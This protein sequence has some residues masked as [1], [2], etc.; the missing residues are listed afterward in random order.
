MANL[1]PRLAQKTQTP[2]TPASTA[3][4]QSVNSD[5]TVSLITAGGTVITANYFSSFAPNVGQIVHYVI[6]NQGY[7]V[8]TGAIANAESKMAGILVSKSVDTNLYNDTITLISFD[9]I[10]YDG[11]E[12]FNS[13]TNKFTAPLPGLYWATTNQVFSTNAT[14]FRTIYI[15][16]ETAATTELTISSWS[17]TTGSLTVVINTSTDHGL[18]AGN[19]VLIDGLTTAR[20]NGVWT[21]LGITDSN[22]FTFT[23]LETTAASGTTGTATKRNNFVSISRSPATSGSTHWMETN[24]V[25]VLGKGDRLYAAAYQN[26]TATLTS[27][28]SSP[29]N[30]SVRYIGPA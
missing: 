29:A 5:Y 24:G 3:Y 4:V 15:A 26:S 28:G 21:V 12:L 9:T 16:R 17:R 23:S 30:L 6:D 13:L 2:S 25:C 27:S 1:S 18:S 8:V 14:G 22:T 20:L 7:F 11:N 19:S 10:E